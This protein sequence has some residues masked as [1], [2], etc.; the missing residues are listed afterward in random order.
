MNH[1]PK[2]PLFY[3]EKYKYDEYTRILSEADVPK[4]ATM[5]EKMTHLRQHVCDKVRPQEVKETCGGTCTLVFKIHGSF[6]KHRAEEFLEAITYNKTRSIIVERDEESRK[7]SV[8]AASQGSNYGHFPGQAGHNAT[9]CVSKDPDQP[10]AEAN[11]HYVLA[12]ET[13]RQASRPALEV[14]FLFFV[15]ENEAAKH[16][17][18][19]VCRVV[20]STLGMGRGLRDAVVCQ[21]ILAHR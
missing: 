13:M 17:S 7:C 19:G 3:D 6:A 21:T 16:M 14:P 15:K 12:R 4:G 1:E 8:N 5:L 11:W 18:F 9:K 2:A 10:M 20:D